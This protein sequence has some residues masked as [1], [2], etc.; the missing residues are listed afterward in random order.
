MKDDAAGSSG[1]G[2]SYSP[3]SLFMM[4]VLSV[5]FVAP[6]VA[7]QIQY[8]L[9]RGELRA[10]SDVAQTQLA[11]LEQPGET[12]RLVVNRVSPAVVHIQADRSH[13]A[14]DTPGFSS[15]DRFDRGEGSGV[16]VDPAGFIVTNHHVIERSS[17]IRV[18]LSDGR[19]VAA[20]V[21]GN[22]PLTDISLLRIQAGNLIAAEWGDSSSLQV[23]DWVL[24]LG[25]PFGLDHSVT[26]GIVSAKGRRNVVENIDYQDFVQT[27]AAVNPGNSGGPLVNLKGQI[28]GIN[29]AIV[30]QS[31]QGVSFA[32]PSVIAQ[33]VLKRLKEDGSFQRGY[34]GVALTD[35]TPENSERLGLK[36]TQGAQVDQIVPHSPA[37][38]AGLQPGDVVLKWGDH[39]IQDSTDLRFRVAHAPLG[40]RVPLEVRRRRQTLELSVVVAPR[41]VDLS[42]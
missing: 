12:F 26:A 8:A 27:D 19:I 6:Y 28:I 20:Q 16:I 30:G 11:A 1:R 21:V 32:I 14:D 33:E 22:D 42:R 41:P 5:T 40:S 25:S 38:G 4:L 35:L 3:V 18:K 31:Y 24:A 29:T 34:L 36:T 39:L 17:R 13:N 7:E 15:R 37:Q 23:G 9:V 10:K 2:L